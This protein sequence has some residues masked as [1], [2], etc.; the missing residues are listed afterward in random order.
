MT[1]IGAFACLRQKQISS[2]ILKIGGKILHGAT[3]TP[4]GSVINNQGRRLWEKLKN[5]EV[6]SGHS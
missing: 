2:D 1:N 6:A 4:V 3:T 5:N